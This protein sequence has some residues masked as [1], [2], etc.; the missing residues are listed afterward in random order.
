MLKKLL[1]KKIAKIVP[2]WLILVVLTSGTA[3]ASIVYISNRV[4]TQVTVTNAPVAIAGNFASTAYKGVPVTTTFTY[5]VGSTAVNGYLE[6]S[7]VG[8]FTSISDVYVY[9]KIGSVSFTPAA[10]NGAVF[11]QLTQGV[12]QCKFLYAVF[13][14]ADPF[15]FAASASGTI[16]VTTTYYVNGDVAANLQVTSNTA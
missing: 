6:F 10:Q 5:T 9:A 7:F 2:F 13:P 12:G 14:N 15:N 1:A 11:T 3:V 8:P 16:E 4:N